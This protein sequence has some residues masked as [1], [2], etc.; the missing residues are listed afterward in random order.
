M[1]QIFGSVTYCGDKEVTFVLSDRMVTPMYE[2]APGLYGHKL[3]DPTS[4]TCK[5]RVAGEHIF[6]LG[7]TLGKTGESD[8]VFDELADRIS[9]IPYHQQSYAAFLDGIRN[10]QRTMKNGNTTYLFGTFGHRPRFM[11]GSIENGRLTKEEEKDSCALHR[12]NENG[13][14]GGYYWYRHWLNPEFFK[15][16]VY[17]QRALQNGSYSPTLDL[18]TEIFVEEM[19]A[20][21][22]HNLGVSSKWDAFVEVD[23]TVLTP[24][25]YTDG[26]ANHAGFLTRAKNAIAATADPFL[27][28]LYLRLAFGGICR[29][30]YKAHDYPGFPFSYYDRKAPEVEA[31]FVHLGRERGLPRNPLSA[32]DIGYSLGYIE[33]LEKAFSGE[34]PLLKIP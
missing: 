33:T 30:S 18:V 21:S 26:I 15:G 14:E 29:V 27:R 28:D 5:V 9:P 12:N 24:D 16:T 8:A 6:G 2:L 13:N 11:V 23:G 3:G 10:A 31:F 7:G 22:R 34:L 19:F 25:I 32:D 1:T 4:S 17:Q 20:E